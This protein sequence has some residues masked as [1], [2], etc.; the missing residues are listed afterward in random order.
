MLLFVIG[1]PGRFAEWCVAATAEIARRALGPTEVI[2]ANTLEE[3]AVGM[4]RT[5]AARAVVAVG[6]DPHS[7]TPPNL[8]RGSRRPA[9]RFGRDRPR[10]ATRDRRRGPGGGKSL[11]RDLDDSS[12]GALTL[13]NDRDVGNPVTI[14]A[15]IARHFGLVVSNSAIVEIIGSLTAAGLTLE[16]REAAAV[17]WREMGLRRTNCGWWKARSP[18]MRPTSRPVICRQ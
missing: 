7:A 1:L 4:I 3:V 12:P 18:P 6:F 11:R 2:C 15:A 17:E 16:R 5:G 13:Y 8:C 14:A 10:A 9:R